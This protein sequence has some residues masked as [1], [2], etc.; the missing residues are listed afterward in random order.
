MNVKSRETALR[1]LMFVKAPNKN[2]PSYFTQDINDSIPALG[3]ETEF[4]VNFNSNS[5]TDNNIKA[6][7]AE[8][9]GIAAIILAKRIIFSQEYEG[10][11]EDRKD[12]FLAI[13]EW[14]DAARKQDAGQQQAV[15]DLSIDGLVTKYANAING[16]SP[17][18]DL[19]KALD[20]IQEMALNNI[21]GTLMQLVTLI[22]IGMDLVHLILVPQWIL[23][24][25]IQQDH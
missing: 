17:E 4:T 19:K 10:D 8:A 1:F 9:T 25:L 15:N 22:I 2:A 11:I 21:I 7:A 20:L 3:N 18:S 14:L 6:A 13:F 16:A 24:L 5:P 12:E 23:L